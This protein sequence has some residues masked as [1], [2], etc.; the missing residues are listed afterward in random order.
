MLGVLFDLDGTLLDLDLGAFLR[1]YFDAIGAVASARFPGVD[2]MSGILASTEAMQAR[3]PGR[4]NRDVF[5]EDFAARTG[6]DLNRSWDVFE[7]FYRDVFPTLGE[8]Y[9][10]MPGGRE[11]VA[12]ALEIGCKV[13]V[14]TQPIFPRLAIEHRLRWAGLADV[15]F[16]AITTY[17][18]MGACKPHGEYFRQT[19]A[20][21][22]CRP[23]ECIMVGD[24]RFLDMPAA[25]VGMRTFYV[26]HSSG[27]VADF[28]GTLGDLTSLLPRLA[29][30]DGA[31]R[32]PAK[33]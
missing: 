7:G 12:C 21:L 20:M 23:S 31:A 3:H 1:G 4:T 19:A 29:R 14:A 15:P 5:Y 22:G 30:A 8:G 2:V 26:G 28:T 16:D 18:I 13:A 33:D 6:I 27:V 25:D 32:P 24:D 10:P 17:E 11:A 9:R